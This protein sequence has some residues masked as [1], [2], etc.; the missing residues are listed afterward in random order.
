MQPLDRFRQRMRIAFFS[1]EI[2]LHPDIHTYSGGLG[3]LAGD[4]ARSCADLGLPVAFV[5]L[6]S[7]AG[8]VQQ[9]IDAEGRQRVDPNPWRPEEWCEPVGA[10]VAIEL[11]GRDVWIRPW[12]YLLSC[13]LGYC[14]PV[15]LLD[16]N[17]EQNS[18]QDRTITDRLYGGDDVYRLKQEAVLGIGGATVLRALGFEIETYHLNE[19][20]A[21]LLTLHLLREYRREPDPLRAGDPLY[22]RQH[23]RDR[24]VFTTHT[25]VEAAFD[26]FPYELVSQ[27]L[28]D[29]IEIAELKPLAGNNH[30]NM[31]Q[32]ALN[33]SGFINGVS[34]QHAET[35][36]RLFPGYRVH[37]ITNGVHAPTWTHASFAR[38]Y[39]AHFPQWAHEPEVLKDVDQLPDAV[40][41]SA[42]QEAKGALVNHIRAKTGLPLQE[43]VPLIG[44]ARR[45]TG[46]KRPDLLFADVT[47]LA[48]IARE[49][50][51]Q[52]VFAGIAHPRDTHG[53]QLIAE[54][55]QHIRE[56]RPVIPMAFLPNYDMRTGSLLTAGADVWLNTPLP[57]FE[58]S[59]TSGMKAALNGV[60]NLSVLDGW[61]REAH[62]EGVTGWAL[63]TRQNHDGLQDAAD[64]Y[65]KL[66]ESILPLYYD[67]RSRWIWMMKQAISKIGAYFNTQR[68]MRRYATEAYLR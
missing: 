31:T 63:G 24:C 18:P 7:R 11:E 3:V 6:I 65:S 20:H 58:A 43:G 52:V 23:V 15:L 42:H 21:A 56:L 13:P 50:P 29:Y 28:G 48:A 25:P 51:F 67:D 19:G 1:M 46:Y 60:L 2:A 47:R 68:V 59:G 12:L 49:R 5:T 34:R 53:A 10:M 54:L 62:I 27:V 45:M 14:V 16:T 26:K 44:F 39:D 30:L 38:F 22:E 4:M 66:K 36:S 32:L 57:P 64:L 17:L 9:K 41:W 35:T 55:N 33:L 40:I 37:A 8:Y 61:W